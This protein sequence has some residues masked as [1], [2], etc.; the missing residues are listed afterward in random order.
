M[1]PALRYDRPPELEG[2]DSLSEIAR[3]I[4]PGATVLDLGAATGKLGAYLRE[5]KGCTCDGVELEPKAAAIARPRYRTLLELDLEQAK[6]AEHFTPGVYDAIICADVLEHLRDP[7]RTLDQLLELLAPGGRVLL[8]IPNVGYAGVIAGLLHGEFA[9]RP[10]GLLDD[11]HVRFFTRSSLLQLIGKHGFRAVSV[12]P[13]HLPVHLSE[14]RESGADTLSP[15]ALSALL[16]HPD[17]LTYQFIV[18][19]VP[20]AGIAPSAPSGQAVPRFTVQLY[21]ALDGAF[22]ETNSTLASG[23][24]GEEHQ[25]IELRIPPL[26]RAPSALRFDVADRPGFVRLHAVSLQDAANAP[27]WSWDGK[28]ASLRRPSEMRMLAGAFAGTL[29]CTGADPSVELPLPAEALARLAGGGVLRV[30]TSWPFSGDYALANRLIDERERAW[31]AERSVL[32]QSL[33]NLRRANTAMAKVQTSLE[34]SHAALSH[35]IEQLEGPPRWQRLLRQSRRS[36]LPASFDFDLVPGPR[37]EMVAP[38][39]W[40]AR[41]TDPHF[42]LR[43]RANHLPVGWSLLEADLDLEKPGRLPPQLYL[44]TGLGFSE[45]DVLRLPRPDGG[46][47]AVE[48]WLPENLI[49]IRFDPTDGEGN[50]R[51]SR[52][53]LRELGK[54]RAGVRFAAPLAKNLVVHPERVPG[55]VARVWSLF[56]SSGARG[57]KNALVERSRKTGTVRYGAWV[58]EFDRLRPEDRTAIAA[59]ISSLP[60]RPRFSVLMPV[61]DTKEKWLRRAIESVREQLYPDWQLCIVDDASTRP[62][63]RRVLDAAAGSD[64]RIRVA[65]RKKNGHISAASNDALALAEGDYVVLLDHDDELAPHALYMMAEEIVAHPELEVAYSDED[66]IDAFGDRYEPH[67]K[68][69]WNPDLLA[70]QNYFSHLTCYR[71]SLVRRLGGFREGYEGS[72]DYDLLLR[73]TAGVPENAV[74]HVPHVLYHWR[75]ADGSTAANARNKRYAIDA[76]LKALRERYP[77]A[78][79]SEGPFPTTYR[80]RHPLPAHPPLT[81]LIVPTRDGRALLEQAIR[82]IREKTEY[83][84]FEIVIVDNQST[85]PATLDYLKSLETTGQARILRYEAPFNYSAI[86]NFAVREAHGDVV[87]LLNNDVEVIE[88]EWLTELVS[89]AIRDEVGAVGCKLLY[90]DR[91]IQHAGV[92]AGLFGVGGHVFKQ[93]PAEAPGY[94]GRA[95][96]IQNLSICTAACL[97]IRKSTYLKVGG[98]DEENLRIA[99]NDVDFCLRV[100]KAGFRNVYT[101]YAVLYHHESATRGYEDT[102]EKQERFQR[103]VELMKARWA[104]V[105]ETDP[106]YNPN[107]SLESLQMELSW[108]PRAAK[109]WKA[110]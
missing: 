41:D 54:I 17:A 67:F 69:D 52:I 50:F 60:V 25:H 102:P 90:P 47:I 108:P 19:A 99:F 48:V 87:C 110:T 55:A 92:I 74:R 93:L 24:M 63:V 81:T 73:A 104:G 8:S 32:L 100:A 103:E 7:G 88:P 58:E 16:S 59:R 4:A 56:R 20:G 12:T 27:V 78:E 39:R 13:L 22:R 71:T 95:Q 34:E 80:V 89:H 2:E 31:D 107:L 70:S 18:E 86:N 23:M 45:R 21:W 106:A 57:L 14:F 40:T 75:S 36:L 11:T 28:L 61:Y 15:G 82:S 38:G 9:Y 42:V 68:P 76:A 65:F 97:A 96:L 6:L 49:G 77:R 5:R 105:L 30:E 1:D 72:Q 85:D 53:T 109:P 83:P 94:F 51:L 3:L 35:R 43:P 79:V 66:K 33:E 29:L 98:L 84:R 64:P 91:T 46:K 62:A 101:P 10:T 44:D 26:P 37:L